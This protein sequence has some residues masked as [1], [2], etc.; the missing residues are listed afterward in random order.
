MMSSSATSWFSEPFTT[1]SLA[2]F[3]VLLAVLF[4]EVSERFFR[5]FERFFARLAA[6]RSFAVFFLFLLVILVRLAVLDRLPVPN[7]GIH[8]EFSYLLM[9]DTFAHG[10]LA[11]PS[12]PLWRSF[13][14]F[15]VL[16]TPT[17]ASKYPVAQGLLLALGQLLGHPW[18]GVLL[19][20]AAMAAAFVWMLQAWMPARWAFLAGVLA[21]LKLCVACYWINSYWGGAAAAIG[22]AMVLGA[23]GR[24]RRKASL[25][26]G[27]LLGLGAAILLNSRPY[28]S[29]FFGAPVGIAL[30]LWLFAASQKEKGRARWKFGFAPA[31]CIL[32]FTFC[33]MAYYNWR[34]THN[35][36]DPP[37]AYAIRS[38]TRAA[39]FV[40]Q[41][42][43]PP[44][45][46]D[47]AELDEFYNQSE[48]QRYDRSWPKLKSVYREKL[49]RC[50][51]VFFWPACWLLLPAALFLSRDKRIRL[52]FFALLA[53]LFGYCLVAW[54]GP[55][56][57]AP[58]A[59]AW[60]AFLV[61]CIRHLRA[62]RPFGRP[63][64]AALSRAIF[65]ALLLGIS[66]LVVQRTGDPQGWGGWGL[67][68]RAQ[69]KDALE[70][71]PG[72]HVVLVRYGPDHS[73][74]EEW[75]FNGAEIDASKIIWARDLPGERNDRLL[76][77]YPDRT[78][79]LVNPESYDVSVFRPQAASP[80]PAPPR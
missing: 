25:S 48:V 67:V 70:S 1:L 52:L 51:E 80:A 28:E 43:G 78:I 8:D 35:P 57:L 44:F 49:W 64:G 76:A 15:H 66:H 41:A 47:V 21:A 5:L 2:C 27:V 40:W 10:R 73:V 68:D 19:S 56:Y 32:L 69:L 58:A 65:F 79:W 9:G 3:F 46:Y 22:G 60:F 13:E 24:L 54:P 23:F 17:Y 34:V 75:V 55:H 45:H 7:P 38:N 12:H 62:F 6:R 26:N 61:Q 18:I 71:T 59:G 33:A 31:A 72:K 63:I 50:A 37:M 36:F 53:T 74:H 39:M 16:W 11:N 4:P 42:P 20:A 30:L 77:Y 29:L 14:T